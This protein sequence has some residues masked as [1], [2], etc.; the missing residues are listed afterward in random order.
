MKALTVKRWA[1]EA[2]V[3]GAKTTEYRS[4]GTSHRGDLTITVSK[5]GGGDLGG[6]AIAIVKV[7]GSKQIGPGLYA[8]S[9]ADVRKITPFAVRGQL[10]IFNLAPA[11][12]GGKGSGSG[13]S[14][15]G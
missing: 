15:R 12:P 6:K 3:S 9:L 11:G 5:D 2:I 1:A 13:G 4:F 14:G 10:G 7:T 8:W